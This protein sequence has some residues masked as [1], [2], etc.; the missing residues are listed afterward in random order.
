[1]RY[2]FT[3][4]KGCTQEN[5]QYGLPINGKLGAWCKAPEG[6]IEDGVSCGIGLHLM[7]SVCPRYAPRNYRCFEAQGWGL[8]G[9]DKEKA[10]Y[11]KVRL[12][13]ELS[14][15]E[16]DWG[17]DK[18]YESKLGKPGL[19]LSVAWARTASFL[20]RDVEESLILSYL[21]PLARL[22]NKG[23]QVEFIK[24]ASLRDSMEVSLR[25]SLWASLRA[26]LRVSLWNSLRASLGGNPGNS[27]WASLLGSLEVSL[28]VSLGI[29]LRN[30]LRD[31]LRGASSWGNLWDNLRDSLVYERGFALAGKSKPELQGLL[32]VWKAGACPL[33][34]D[35]KGNFIV[36]CYK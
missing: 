36:L 17:I 33:G 35:K 4:P 12:L 1:M 28:E 34:W 32:E 21:Q 30:S 24:M 16:I 2:K 25:N 3:N 20:D 29:S 5:F 26:S 15:R 18:V 19:F 31:S 11:R 13:R 8:L 27:L 10:R 22:L 23:K 6:A 14:P 7:K 9:Q